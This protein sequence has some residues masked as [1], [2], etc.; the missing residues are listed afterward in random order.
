MA[1]T[2]TA[3]TPASG[4]ADSAD[5]W[6]GRRLH[7]VVMPSGQKAVVQFPELGM[8]VLANAVPDDLVELA[9]AEL[10]HRGGVTAAYGEQVAAALKTPSPGE[11]AP[12]DADA[13]SAGAEAEETVRALT[14]QLGRLLKW[15][16]AEHVLVDPKVTVDQLADD[17]FP[18]ADLDWLYGVA[19]RRVDEDALGRRLGVAR[20]DEFATFRDAH[21]CGAGCPACLEV[22]E[23]LSTADLGAL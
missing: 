15:L 8:L 11:A 21:G 20:L 18:L 12:T 6:A 1:T 13:E 10:T 4:W 2:D 19:M 9:R 16:V 17:R 22:V 5:Q 14:D 3:S 7:K 23:A